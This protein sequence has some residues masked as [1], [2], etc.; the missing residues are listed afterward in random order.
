MKIQGRMSCE[1]EGRDRGGVS[2]SHEMPTIPNKPQEARTEAWTRFSL[3]A[4]EGTN[5]T[6][7]WSRSLNPQNCETIMSVV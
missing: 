7:T 1:D 4:S 3:E 5:P 6:D 2:A